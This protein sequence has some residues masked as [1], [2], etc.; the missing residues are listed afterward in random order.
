M[1]FHK[2]QLETGHLEVAGL[3]FNLIVN[4]YKEQLNTSNSYFSSLPVT[5]PYTGVEFVKYITPEGFPDF[6]IL[7]EENAK[8]ATFF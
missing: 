1:H 3:L 4:S 7:P 8:G 6:S 2:E 5:G